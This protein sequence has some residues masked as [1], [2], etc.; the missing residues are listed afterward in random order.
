MLI[1]GLLEIRFY[2]TAED[3]RVRI[4]KCNQEKIPFV[5]YKSTWEHIMSSTS[6]CTV[7]IHVKVMIKT[8]SRY[9]QRLNMSIER[10][11]KSS[12]HH[13]GSD[14]TNSE[15]L[16]LKRRGNEN[17][18]IRWCY[19]QNCFKSRN[20]ST[21]RVHAN[22]LTNMCELI[23]NWTAHHTCIHLRV[24][25]RDPSGLSRCACVCTLSCG[26][27]QKENHVTSTTHASRQFVVY[28]SDAE[29]VLVAAEKSNDTDWNLTSCFKV[30][31]FHLY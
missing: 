19:F 14:G 5:Q 4:T 23:H 1:H 17:F 30:T 20:L 26:C 22:M 24:S 16:K 31:N 9:R 25:I 7:V 18:K 29:A 3:V 2:Q 11:F 8:I 28:V 10:N 27:L 6:L 13:S 21:T 15:T 12:T